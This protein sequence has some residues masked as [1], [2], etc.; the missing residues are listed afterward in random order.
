M[1]VTGPF[2]PTVWAG[3][4]V[5]GLHVGWIVS[6]VVTLVALIVLIILLVLE[7]KLPAYWVKGPGQQNT[8]QLGVN[9]NEPSYWWSS[10]FAMFFFNAFTTALTKKMMIWQWNLMQN[11]MSLNFGVWV[12]VMGQELLNS[13]LGFVTLFFGLMNIYFFVSA[14]VGKSLGVMLVGRLNKKNEKTDKL[15]SY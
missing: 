13:S 10:L 2:G 12:M 7:E 4:T 5:H 14:A 9:F 8:D 15:S 6:L 3:N 11:G 1:M